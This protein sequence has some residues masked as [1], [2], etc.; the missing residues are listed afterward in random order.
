ME[1]KSNSSIKIVTGIGIV[2]GL[3]NV[4]LS[5]GPGMARNLGIGLLA[6]SII[7]G[8]AILMGVGSSKQP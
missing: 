8:I 4:W 3:L 7:C 1:P 2:L 5:D 6:V